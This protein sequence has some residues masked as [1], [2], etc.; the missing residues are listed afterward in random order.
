V[1]DPIAPVLILNRNLAGTVTAVPL[2]LRDPTVPSPT[3]DLDYRSDAGIFTSELQQILQRNQQTLVAGVRFQAGE[4]DNRVRLADSTATQLAN[5]TITSAVAVASPP[6]SQNFTHEFG[7]F[8]AYLY[9]T[10]QPWEPLYLTAGVAYDVVY[11]PLNFRYSPTEDEQETQKRLSPKAGIIWTPLKSTTL[12]AA[13]SQSLGGVGF[14]Q[15]FRLEPTQVAG[16]NQAYRSLIPESVVG[17]ISV[18]RFETISVALDQKFPTSTYF[19]VQAELLHSKVNRTLGTVDISGFPPTFN[20]SSTRQHL[21]YYERNLSFTFNQLVGKYWSLG[22][23]YKLSHADLNTE[24]PELTALTPSARQ[25][26]EAILHQVNL[27]ILFN[28]SCGFFSSFESI[29]SQQSNQGYTPDIPGD[30]FWQLNVFAGYRFAQRRAEIRLGI[31]NLTDQDYKLNPL[32]LTPELP[33]DRTLSA[34]LRF[35]F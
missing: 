26:L 33:R 3:A 25:D 30:D 29:W 8:S 18:P 34:S 31:L 14:D 35:S 13:Y 19:G 5:N 17:A 15:S 10:W 12:R 24:L 11:Y 28:H 2:A 23:R 6:S 16:F 20:D 32:N 21:D 7:R 9:D 4:F 1:D 22:A 27:F